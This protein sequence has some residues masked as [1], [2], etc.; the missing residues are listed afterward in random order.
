MS[1][2]REAMAVANARHAMPKGQGDTGEMGKTYR[3]TPES[4]GMKV[5]SA[6]A[7]AAHFRSSAGPMGKGGRSRHKAERQAIR[8]DFKR[9]EY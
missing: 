9:G 5:R 2:L 7:V 1:Y 3:R 8:K 6:V 4:K